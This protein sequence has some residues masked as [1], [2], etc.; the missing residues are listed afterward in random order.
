M[1]A[2]GSNSSI[3][4]IS[5]E[6]RFKILPAELALKKCIVA[7]TI[8]ENM[9]LCRFLDAFIQSLKKVSDLIIVTNI[10]EAMSDE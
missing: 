2:V 7:L 1:M 4:P 9:L 3:A 8:F 5:L 6:N 10:M